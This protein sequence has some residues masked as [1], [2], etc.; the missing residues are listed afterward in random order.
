MRNRTVGLAFLLVGVYLLSLP[1]AGQVFYPGSVEQKKA[2]EGAQAPK[3]DLHD[4]SGIWRGAG[5]RVPPPKDPLIG[6][7]HATPLMGGVPAKNLR[8]ELC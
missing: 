7:A 2:A 4:L 8:D 6:D 5:G 1:A 3:Y